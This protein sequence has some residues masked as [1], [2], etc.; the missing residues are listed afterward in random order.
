MMGLVVRLRSGRAL[1]ALVIST[2][3]VLARRWA[4]V[5]EGLEGEL[6]DFVD[7]LVVFAAF[8]LTGD[9]HAAEPP[10][11]AG[12]AD[13]STLAVALLWF[14]TIGGGMLGCDAVR[15]VPVLST[16]DAVGR[17]LSHVLG[18]CKDAGA[19]ETTLARALEAYERKEHAE[20]V[21]LAVDMV[22]NLRAAGRDVPEETEVLLRL[23]QGALAAQAIDDGMS[24][25]SGEKPP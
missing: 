5:P 19:D 25:L 18:W 11:R 23:A 4:P 14:A 3:L 7:A 22:K 2:G 12:S 16:A 24:A 21:S 15:G 20:A 13:P 6:N 8:M 17:G 1:L 10:K 9:A